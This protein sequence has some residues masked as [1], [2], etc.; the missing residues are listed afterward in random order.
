MAVGN[1]FRRF[2][3]RSRLI[4]M[5]VGIMLALALV[6]GS[7]TFGLV[8]FNASN[9]AFIETD[10][11]WKQRMAKLNASLGNMRRYEKDMII[12]MTDE[13]KL[14]DYSNKWT[15]ANTSAY[16]V[17]LDASAHAEE[18]GAT[19]KIKSADEKL[20][21]YTTRFQR[22]AKQLE[23]GAFDTPSAAARVML[24][25]REAYATL[26]KEVTS[27]DAQ[28]DERAS[29]Q[30]AKGDRVF[31][32]A[33]FGV[34]A[35]AIMAA[36][37]FCIAFFWF[38]RSTTIPIMELIQHAEA[39]ADG[40]LA[41][42]IRSI[43]KDEL[44]ELAQAMSLMT[45]S[46]SKVVAEVRDS[47]ESIATASSEIAQGNADLS[48]RTESQAGS[49]QQTASSVEQLTGTVKQ[50][51]D[52]AR[53]ANQLA[54]AASM[55]ATRGGEVVQKV[56]ATMS[57]INAS[58]KKISEIISVIDGIAFQTNILALNAAV[59]AARAGEQGRGFAVVASEVRSLAQR[60]ADAAKEIKTLIGNSVDQVATGSALVN[61]AG[62]SMEEIVTSV[63]RVTDIIAEITAA[64][65]EQSG[66]IE[67]VNTAV[68]QLDQMTQQ[69]AALVE[70]SAAAASSL[71]D[72]AAR[73]AQT[74]KQFS[75]AHA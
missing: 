37:A 31:K 19:D 52:A 24:G 42:D 11:A 5:W 4:A 65:V 10:Y 44:S 2:S 57:G 56:V 9:K 71:K 51:A 35:S 53:Q 58:S 59:E 67:Q 40:D 66:G 69:N 17:L 68:G 25:A 61:E 26:E 30:A 39:I 3:I 55:D 21:E 47:S 13:A 7:G 43:G 15:L 49:L 23:N 18:I 22:V 20:K 29:E 33:V 6:G 36:V 27:I 60:S 45:S 16:N 62:E 74:V 34:I 12:H 64:T 63:K 28:L 41:R 70:Q 38:V 73:L 54:S 14:K 48:S 8:S 50:N 72:Q 1:Y 32:N 46:L 75:I